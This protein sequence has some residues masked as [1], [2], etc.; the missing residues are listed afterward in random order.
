MP[1]LNK[2]IGGQQVS[3]WI[4]LDGIDDGSNPNQIVIQVG[5][6]AAKKDDGTVE[7]TAWYEWFPE[8]VVFISHD[9]FSASAGDSECY[10]H[11]TVKHF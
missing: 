6:D 10:A 4:G 5:F 1:D 7:Y 3:Y 9:D 2:A 8:S 11:A